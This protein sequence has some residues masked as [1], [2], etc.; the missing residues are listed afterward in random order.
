MSY[1]PCPKCDNLK[2]SVYIERE[3]PDW[4]FDIGLII[5]LLTFLGTLGWMIWD[6]YK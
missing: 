3:R 5:I 1:R 6:T 2:I 4:E